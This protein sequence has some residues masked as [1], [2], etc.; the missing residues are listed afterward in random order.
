MGRAYKDEQDSSVGGAQTIA[1]TS[2][3]VDGRRRGLV[4]SD[5]A[6]AAPVWRLAAGE[7][8]TPAK[9]TKANSRRTLCI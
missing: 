9:T 2:K 6:P 8:C 3:E 5:E 1:Q 7:I 4:L